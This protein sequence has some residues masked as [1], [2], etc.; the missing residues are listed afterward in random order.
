VPGLDHVDRWLSYEC[1]GY[2]DSGHIWRR[3]FRASAT[4]P[5]EFFE[6]RRYWSSPDTWIRS[7]PIDFI[8]AA[9]RAL[10]SAHTRNYARNAHAK[11]YELSKTLKD[12]GECATA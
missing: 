9:S 8:P 3:D 7:N 2:I 5:R 4:T 6:V 1:P 12:S 10:P 11:Q